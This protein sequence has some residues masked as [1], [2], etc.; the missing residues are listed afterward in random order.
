LTLCQEQ[1]HPELLAE[2]LEGLAGSA[3]QQGQSRRAAR[4]FGAAY[5]L[6]EVINAPRAPIE[7]VWYAEVMAQAQADLGSSAYEAA[8]AQGRR[9]PLEDAI[10]YALAMGEES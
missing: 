5:E 2:C 8:W 3:A 9:M 10:A 1:G 6:R 7:D 4:L